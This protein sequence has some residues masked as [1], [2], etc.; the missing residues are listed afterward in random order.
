[1]FLKK[2]IISK[3]QHKIQDL[4]W[5]SQK[6]KTS[7]SSQGHTDTTRRSEEKNSCILIPAPLYFLSIRILI[8][9]TEISSVQQLIP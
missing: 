6:L 7:G 9:F 2:M 1:M 4:G 3:D 5:G 8:C